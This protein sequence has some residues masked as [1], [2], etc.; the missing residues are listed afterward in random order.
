MRDS[1]MLKKIS[2]VILLWMFSMSINQVFAQRVNETK[3]SFNKQDVASYSIEYD[4]SK[5]DLQQVAES[6]FGK[7]INGK[8]SKA[9]GFVQYIAASWS[10]MPFDK[11]DIYY[12]VEGNK[13]KST[14][15]ILVSMGYD[16]FVSSST[17]PKVLA[18]LSMFAS[19][20]QKEIEAYQLNAKI[21][22]QEKKI[23]DLEKDYKK[24][25]KKERK[26][27][28]KIDKLNKKIGK[29]KN[30]YESIASEIDKQKQFL[31][32]LQKQKK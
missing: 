27:S 7:N 2:S 8:K 1:I 32:D 26:Y 20:F 11:G 18:S 14:L 21:V 10:I 12:K 6:Y 24:K 23:N 19:E 16:N 3:L 22:A 5:A 29:N 4:V 25:M 31:E 28:K 30:K 13:K 15:I 9:E 17:E